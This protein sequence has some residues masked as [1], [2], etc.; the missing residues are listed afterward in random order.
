MQEIETTTNHVSR[1]LEMQ[2]KFSPEATLECML[3]RQN[4]MQYMAMAH[5]LSGQTLPPDFAAEYLALQKSIKT[6]QIELLETKLNDMQYSAMAHAH[7]GQTL[8]AD[9]GREFEALKQELAN[10]TSDSPA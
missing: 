5:A 8:P 3:K 4:E 7:S 9:F 2:P 10:L 1:N 6:A